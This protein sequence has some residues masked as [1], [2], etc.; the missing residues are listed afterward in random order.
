MEYIRLLILYIPFLFLGG[1][2]NDD[3]HYQGNVKERL[4][5]IYFV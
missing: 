2:Y 5:T 4:H 3:K 1:I